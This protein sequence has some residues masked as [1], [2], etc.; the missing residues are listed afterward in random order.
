MIQA[1]CDVQLLVVKRTVPSS[2]SLVGITCN[3]VAAREKLSLASLGGISVWLYHWQD[4]LSPG[5]S[6]TELGKRQQMPLWTRK[7]QIPTI[8][9]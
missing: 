6:L 8:L 9:Q 5:I 2:T 1:P 7:T 4:F 3:N